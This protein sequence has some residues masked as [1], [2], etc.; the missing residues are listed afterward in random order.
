VTFDPVAIGLLLL[1]GGL[2]TRAA[3]A[4]RRRGQPLPTLQWLFWW[5]GLGLLAFALMG[6]LDGL[7]DQVLT[8]HMAQHLL[9]GDVAAP[10]LVAGVRS[11]MLQWF[12]PRPVLVPLARSAGLRRAG[13]AIR[14]PLPALAIFVVSLYGWHFAASFDAALRH[15]AVHALQHESF[16]LAN[17]LVWWVVL[18]PGK[19]RMPG[20]L[21][22]IPYIF[23][24]RMAS[25]FLG[26]GLV[27]SRSPWYA[28]FYGDR[29][30]AH[31]LR[32]LL[33]QQYAGGMMM[34]F[35]IIVMVFA[36]TLFF[37]RAAAD[38]DRALAST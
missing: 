12:L 31:G 2:W 7:A 35:D 24:A 25:M 29:P 15:P 13:A 27:F 4:L 38:A 30:R 6:P 21:W 11:P 28:G 14:R 33:D 26:V 17:G 3:L 32:P 8:A 22:K 1:A 10:L 34:S 20:E 23:A 37:W 9:L 5:S 18:E 36:L 16:L 19:R